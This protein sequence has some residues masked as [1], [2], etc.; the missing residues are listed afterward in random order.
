M[1]WAKQGVEEAKLTR[2]RL[3]L[4]SSGDG[5]RLPIVAVLNALAKVDATRQAPGFDAINSIRQRQRRAGR[6]IMTLLSHC[7]D[8]DICVWTAEATSAPAFRR[9]LWQPDRTGFCLT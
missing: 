4:Q 9:L 1:D 6:S 7:Y 5:R 3:E 8:M 2:A